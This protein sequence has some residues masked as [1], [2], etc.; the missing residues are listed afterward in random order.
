MRLE[1]RL[2]LGRADAAVEAVDDALSLDEHE[3]RDVRDLEALGQLRLSVDVDAHD[4]EAGALLAR[5]VGEQALHS[6]C[7]AG[8]L[9]PEEDEQGPCVCAHVTVSS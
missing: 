3:R 6:A 5:E 8:A 7:R 4:L 2:D 1:H 9:R